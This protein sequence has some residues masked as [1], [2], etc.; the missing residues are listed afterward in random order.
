MNR[1]SL[2]S[3]L[4]AAACIAAS[5]RA[6]TPSPAPGTQA[7]GGTGQQAAQSA[8]W[9]IEM[10][11]EDEYMQQAFGVTTFR[12]NACRQNAACGTTGT[13][14]S[15]MQLLWDR[16]FP[17]AEGDAAQQFSWPGQPLIIKWAVEVRNRIAFR[18]SFEPHTALKEV[19]IARDNGSICFLDLDSG[20][21]TRD[22]LETGYGLRSTL[23]AYSN[24]IP[25]L[26][27]GQAES[28]EQT[29]LRQYS[30]YDL[31]EFP[32]I[33]GLD[34]SVRQSA[35]GNGAFLSAALADRM[36][37]TLVTAGSNGFLY[38]IRMNTCFDYRDG[39]LTVDPEICA[40][41]QESGTLPPEDPRTGFAAPVSASGGYLYCAD[42]SGMLRCVESGAMNPVW[43]KDLG[44]A[45]VCAIAMDRQTDRTSLYA[46]NTL[47]CRENGKAGVFCLDAINGTE[48]WHRDF[49]V[50]KDGGLSP[51]PVGFVSSPVIGKNGLDSLVCFTVTGLSETGRKELGLGGTESSA[52]IALEKSTGRTAWAFGMDG[53][54]RSSP[55]AVY[56]GEGE[57]RII[58]CMP[59]GRIVMLAGKDGTV[60]D[61]MEVE[62]AIDCSPAVYRNTMVI[63]STGREYAHV[64]GIS[65]CSEAEE[66]RPEQARETTEKPGNE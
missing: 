63:A 26:C 35:C 29:G 43:E 15:R 34:E 32:L 24:G 16:K 45:V 9:P 5:G 33:D 18:G 58:Q 39:T 48:Y 2:I 23:A 42:L 25:Y 55:V 57:G 62:G 1:R 59:D 44:D 53:Y 28:G 65:L 64:Y 50:E 31:E 66:S 21:L 49:D 4:L 36:T 11:P 20:E 60:L 10:P 12:G 47:S 13:A 52:L 22:P 46:A 37:D 19:I 17:L 41:K 27:V 38:K 6:E 3:V 61:R 14:A 7:G 30:L 8:S 51:E 54:C 40:V 56:D